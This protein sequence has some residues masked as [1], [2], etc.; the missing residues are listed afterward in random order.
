MA[1]IFWSRFGKFTT[2]FNSFLFLSSILIP[3][4]SGVYF[5]PNSPRDVFVLVKVTDSLSIYPATTHSNYTWD[6][7]QVW[8]FDNETVSL[9]H[10]NHQ[11]FM[12]ESDETPEPQ[13]PT[14]HL[15]L[16]RGLTDFD[17]NN[18]FQPGTVY[19]T[20]QLNPIDWNSKLFM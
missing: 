5:V 9:H 17:R 11:L 12:L 7:D 18:V 20:Q 15:S 6:L 14:D 3:V 4:I 13:S 10:S 8:R 1:M 2:P 19:I 16:S